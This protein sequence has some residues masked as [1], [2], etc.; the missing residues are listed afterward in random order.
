MDNTDMYW[1]DIYGYEQVPC[2][3]E[4]GELP[5]D[6]DCDGECDKYPH[7]DCDEHPEYKRKL[8]AIKLQNQIRWK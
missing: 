8:R 1:D 4:N 5:D 6:V 3:D 7:T 2:F